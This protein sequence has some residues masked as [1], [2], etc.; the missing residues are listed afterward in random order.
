L[1]TDFDSKLRELELRMTVKMGGMLFVAVGIIL[2]AM[3][4]MFGKAF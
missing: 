2:G 4:I 1:R 3:R